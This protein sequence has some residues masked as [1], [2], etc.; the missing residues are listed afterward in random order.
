MAVTIGCQK[1][2]TV[3]P[4][5]EQCRWCEEIPGLFYNATPPYIYDNIACFQLDGG[6]IWLNDVCGG[7]LDSIPHYQG[8][9]ADSRRAI[10]INEM[11]L[12]GGGR[13]SVC[14]V[15]ILERRVLWTVPLE[16]TMNANCQH[17]ANSS[18]FF[19][20]DESGVKECNTSGD[21]EYIIELSFVP[22]YSIANESYLLCHDYDGDGHIAV[23]DIASHSVIFERSLGCFI[24]SA[25]VTDSNHFVFSCGQRIDC[26]NFDGELIWS[27]PKYSEA[28]LVCDSGLILGG[29]FSLWALDEATGRQVWSQENAAFSMLQVA[30]GIAYAIDFDVFGYEV[31][32]GRQVMRIVPS[33]SIFGSYLVHDSLIVHSSEYGICGFSI[34]Q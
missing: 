30:D 29:Y 25:V 11:V 4:K 1:D 17:S 5:T 33:Q 20:L 27:E 2:A 21:I 15:D 22:K 12:V 18:R 6:L 8:F 7:S 32:S 24:N 34:V 3:S 16:G 31:S 26:Y 19:L 28:Q 13:A 23:I 9:H 10:G 14:A